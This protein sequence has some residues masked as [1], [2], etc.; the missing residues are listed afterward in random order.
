MRFVCVAAL[1]A[2]LA[3][4]PSA[5]PAS[6]TE[7]PATARDTAA[8]LVG[9]EKVTAG[10]S[11]IV[12]M[13]RSLAGNEYDWQVQPSGVNWISG[14][15]RQETFVILL[16]LDPGRYFVSFSSFDKKS[17][18]THVVEV[19]P[20]SPPDPAPVP[21]VP[22]GPAP[23]PDGKYR[24]AAQTLE[25]LSTVPAEKRPLAKQLANSFRGIVSAIAAGSLTKP[26]DVLAQT[27]SSNNAALGDAADLWK[28]FGA[29]L[30]LALETL[31]R[32]GTLRTI[33]DYRAA[34]EEIA[35]GLE[36]GANLKSR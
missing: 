31:D 33:D 3:S 19:D 14:E 18:A 16:D 2:L 25:W 6:T 34:W 13:D 36:A 11:A 12:R 23:L 5:A 24:L 20:F 4:A 28:P 26:A 8:P 15:N 30:Q 32:E 21:P 17:H 9:P 10:K 29:K 22:P 35:V 7:V 27:R 1:M